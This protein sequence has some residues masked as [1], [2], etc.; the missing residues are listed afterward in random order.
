MADLIIQPKND[1]HLKLNNDAGTTILELANDESKLRLAQ[2]N[3]SASDGTTAITTSSANVTLAGS[4]NNIGTATGTFSGT[5]SSSATISTQDY[6]I[7]R[8]SGNQTVADDTQAII[9]F[10]ETADPQGW[11]ASNKFTPQKAGKY[12]IYV[13]GNAYNST[14]VSRNQVY[15]FA[16]TKNGSGLTDRFVQANNDARNYYFYSFGGSSTAIVDFNGSSDFVYAVFYPNNGGLYADDNIIQ[17]AYSEF[18]GFRI[19]P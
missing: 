8:L 17:S 15:Y 19:G 2:N 14:G 18:G 12:F 3:I 6:F 9:S 16:I 5:V 10:V 13:S 11:F 1:D 7:A 4:A